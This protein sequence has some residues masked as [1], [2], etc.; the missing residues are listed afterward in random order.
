MLAD[1]EKAAK[2][3]NARRNPGKTEVG[4]VRRYSPG[5]SFSHT[6]NFEVETPLTFPKSELL[7]I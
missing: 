5:L 2:H 1:T 4:I 7:L 6:C 3:G